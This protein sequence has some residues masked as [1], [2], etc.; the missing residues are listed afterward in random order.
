MVAYVFVAGVF[1]ARVRENW[2][3]LK[4]EFISYSTTFT[5]IWAVAICDYC[6]LTTFPCVS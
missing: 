6:T 2:R 3:H 5:L 1:F 4:L